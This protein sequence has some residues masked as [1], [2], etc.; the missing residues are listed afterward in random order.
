MM[1]TKES[2]ENILN[3]RCESPDKFLLRAE[4]TLMGDVCDDCTNNKEYTANAGWIWCCGFESN[5]ARL[6]C[7]KEDD[8]G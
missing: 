6:R 7:S 8:I 5:D 4:S 3:N 1:M 2:I